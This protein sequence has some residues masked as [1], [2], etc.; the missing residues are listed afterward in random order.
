MLADLLG[1]TRR[2]GLLLVGEGTH[3]AREVTKALGVPV[4][5]HAAVRR[6]G[7]GRA[8]GRRGQPPRAG[9]PGR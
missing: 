6:E 7:R 3:S 5:A 2:V 9:S 1:G 4:V 8:G